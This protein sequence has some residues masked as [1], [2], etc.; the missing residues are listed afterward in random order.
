MDLFTKWMVNLKSPNQNPVSQL[1]W[2]LADIVWLLI[3]KILIE[4]VHDHFN[5]SSPAAP[6]VQQ[7]ETTHDAQ[8][9]HTNGQDR[10]VPDYL[11]WPCCRDKLN[12]LEFRQDPKLSYWKSTLC[13]GSKAEAYKG[14]QTS[15]TKT[16]NH[17]PKEE[18]ASRKRHKS[19]P[20]SSGSQDIA[21]S[22]WHS[23][24]QKFHTHR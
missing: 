16:H 11:G 24:P 4:F 8:T 15:L 5:T 19:H 6:A 2:I 3:P 10:Q 23:E 22:Y 20:Q 21:H 7:H 14:L 1:L 12:S 13:L 9:H 17:C 18:A